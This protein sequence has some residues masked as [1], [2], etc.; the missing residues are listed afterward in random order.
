MKTDFKCNFQALWKEAQRKD[1]Q[2]WNAGGISEVLSTTLSN[3]V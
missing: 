3:G 1:C 2:V